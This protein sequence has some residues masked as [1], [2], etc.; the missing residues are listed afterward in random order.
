MV[1]VGS[2]SANLP[3]ATP[4]LSTSAC[5]FGST[6]TPITGSGKVIDSKITGLS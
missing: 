3:K 2:S 1:N 5:V 4:I 6:A